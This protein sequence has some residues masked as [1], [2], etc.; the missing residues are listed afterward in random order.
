RGEQTRRARDE[1]VVAGG[2]AVGRGTADAEADA[3]TTGRDAEH[4]VGLVHGH[5]QR[6]EV[7]EAVGARAEH[8]QGERELRGRDRFEHVHTSRVAA[9]TSAAQSSSVSVSARAPGSIP[10]SC[11][12]ATVSRPSAPRSAPRSIFRRCPKPAR[13]SS[14]MWRGSATSTAGCARLVISTSAEST[15]GRGTNTVG[16]TVATTLAVA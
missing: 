7:V 1:I 11:N 12:T 8:A 15:W 2:N 14:N 10:A 6:V 3:R 13:T 5:D 4:V 16:G 9:P